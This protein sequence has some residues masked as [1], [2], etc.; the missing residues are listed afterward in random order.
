MASV[1]FMRSFLTAIS[2]GDLLKRVFAWVLRIIAILDIIFFIVV[3][4]RF[5]REIFRFPSGV[6]VIG[7]IIFQIIFIIVVYM[8]VHA[9]FY[10]ASTI[11]NLPRSDFTVIPIVSVLMR[12]V[13]EVYGAMMLGLGVGG[14]ILAW[15]GG[16]PAF[17]F[18]LEEFVPR[19]PT[20]SGFIGGFILLISGVVIGFMA[21]VIFYFLAEA[22]VVLVDMARNLKITRGV[23]EQY[24]KQ[25]PEASAS[26]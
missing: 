18:L 20:G 17:Y 12:L 13:G 2:E 9:I 16:G 26:I 24:G 25:P 7:G 1:F 21:L 10:R 11:R 8:I 4:I 14:C 22:M 3:W 6:T 5:W 19:M 23:A 15:F